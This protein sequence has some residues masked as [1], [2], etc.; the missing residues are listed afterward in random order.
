MNYELST[1]LTKIIEAG[2]KVLSGNYK[3]VDGYKLYES[4]RNDCSLFFNTLQDV[5]NSTVQSPA[6]I[7][8]GIRFL[9]EL[10]DGEPED[11][12]E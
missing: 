11:N 12:E 6:D 7:R 1:Q 3:V 8:S 5:F 10:L 2:E 9:E 4:W